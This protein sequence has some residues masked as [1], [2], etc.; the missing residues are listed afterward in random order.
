MIKSLI[1]KYIK[2]KNNL[3]NFDQVDINSQNVINSTV[4]TY[5]EYYV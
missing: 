1:I 3:L 2:S 4:N 5:G